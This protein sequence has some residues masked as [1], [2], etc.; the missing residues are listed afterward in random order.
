MHAALPAEHRRRSA[1]L[2]DGH[3]DT[4]ATAPA[5]AHPAIRSILT[6][7]GS[8]SAFLSDLIG[9]LARYSAVG[10]GLAE[11]STYLRN[12]GDDVRLFALNA[13]IGQAA[14]ASMERLLDVVARLLTEQSEAPRRWSRPSPRVRPTPLATSTR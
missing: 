4:L 3:R 9:E 12:M 11:H 10:A 5:G 2:P 7:Y 1:R 13:Q 6:S 8:F 14:S